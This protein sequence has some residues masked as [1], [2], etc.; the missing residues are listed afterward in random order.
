MITLAVKHKYWFEGELKKW[1]ITVLGIILALNE[2]GMTTIMDTETTTCVDVTRDEGRRKSSI[3]HTWIAA[4]TIKKRKYK[5]T[6]R[7]VIDILY[8]LEFFC[9]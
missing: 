4:G 3:L 5:S 7:C 9:G 1:E 6:K 8:W 2:K